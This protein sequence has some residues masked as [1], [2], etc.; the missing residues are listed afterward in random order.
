M[1]RYL[2]ITN[3]RVARLT[4]GVLA[5]AAF[6]W[7]L[8]GCETTPEPP[9][10]GE[11][12]HGAYLPENVMVND[13]ENRTAL[14]LLSRGVQYSVTCPAIQETRLPNGQLQ[15]GVNLRNREGRRIQVQANCEFKDQQGFVLDSTPFENVFMDENAQQGIKF[16][17]M[18]D[19]AV[20]YTVRVREPR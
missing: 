13:L 12:E 17:S 10:P 7:F 4:C 6:A 8:A 1:K 19:K 18:N 14:V 11:Y 2:L 5:A 3:A 16:L 20:S 9:P 15:V